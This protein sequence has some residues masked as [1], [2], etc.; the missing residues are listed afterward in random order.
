[1]V[2]PIAVVYGDGVGPEIM[3]ATLLIL[4]QAKV[5]LAIESVEA[6]EKAYK[7]HWV[8]G[9][10]DSAWSVLSRVNAILKAPIYTPSGTGYHSVN[11]SMRKRLGLYANIR[12]VLSYYPFVSSAK[13]NVDVV[14]IRENEEGAYT[15][16]EYRRSYNLL[17][18]I[19][20][21][22]I[23]NSIRIS[24]YAFEYAKTFGRK[25]VDCLVKDNIM[26]MTDGCFYESFQGVSK[27]YPEI[28]NGKYIVDIGMARLAAKPEDFDVIVTTNL[29]GDIASDIAAEITGS[30][31]MAGSANIGDNSAMFEAVHG[32]APDIAGKNIANPSGLLNA[33][34]MMLLHLGL[35]DK[36]AVIQNAW[37]RTI[38]SGMH[39]ADINGE[40]TVK[41]LGTKEFAAE[42]I[43][44]LGMMPR[45]LPK[46]SYDNVCN[47]SVANYEDSLAT[48]IK[49]E[50]R[51]LLGADIQ[52]ANDGKF[53]SEFTADKIAS[54]INTI[55]NENVS[56][57]VIF[58]KGLNIWPKLYEYKGLH[59]C[60]VLRMANSSVGQSVSYKDL[61]MCIDKFKAIGL[62]TTKIDFLF[63]FDGKPGF[64][65]AEEY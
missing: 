40:K 14:I 46:V 23:F 61:V 15:G 12:P 49:T 57:C 52:V 33:A 4:H 45:V 54:R 34:I 10:A 60:C 65:F 64:A 24:S 5:S 17:E 50:K 38:E 29:Y 47:V 3:E 9:V 27:R 37:L 56:L 8:N 39:T 35:Y 21:I 63:S 7:K 11:V 43:N 6:G 30:V 53:D 26:K 48:A 55:I 59:D 36:A 42:V 32:T 28:S 22:T 16:V 51:E 31:G 62:I 2:I 41:L 1:M 13:P 25:K 19:R 20:S 58:C 18:S 44:N